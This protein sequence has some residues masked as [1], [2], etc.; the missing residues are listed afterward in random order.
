MW[1]SDGLAGM[2][3]GTRSSF[4]WNRLRRRH[5][6]TNRIWKSASFTYDYRF[7]KICHPERSEGP[8]QLACVGRVQ[9]SSLCSE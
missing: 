7:P 1:P 9:T 6:G 4:A 3:S 2:I 8:M 5:E